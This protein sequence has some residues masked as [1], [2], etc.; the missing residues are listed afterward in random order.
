MK[1]NIKGCCDNVSHEKS[2]EILERKI[3][4]SKFL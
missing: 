4:N 1:R 3:K 2:V